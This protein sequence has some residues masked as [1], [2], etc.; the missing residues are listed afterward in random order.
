M[1][2][3]LEPQRHRFQCGLVL[4]AVV[5]TEQQFATG[6]DGTPLG[7][8]AAPVAAVAGENRPTVSCWGRVIMAASLT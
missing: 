6:Q 5:V 7:A 1:S 8:G 4:V 3:A 2:R